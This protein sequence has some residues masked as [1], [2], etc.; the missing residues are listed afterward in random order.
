[1][2]KTLLSWP[3]QHQKLTIFDSSPL[4]ELIC[5]LIRMRGDLSALSESEKKMVF[6]S[7]QNFPSSVPAL[8]N[9]PSLNR[10]PLE[11]IDSIMLVYG[12]LIINS[13]RE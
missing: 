1:M 7:E 8:Q 11:R 4:K 12:L 10:R 6:L 5:Q 9:Y 2:L 13:F 3:A